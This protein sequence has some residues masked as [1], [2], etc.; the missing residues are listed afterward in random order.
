MCTK[1]TDIILAQLPEILFVLREFQESQEEVFA[2]I[3]DACDTIKY[4]IG[5]VLLLS[6]LCGI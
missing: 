4:V 5:K 6:R 3:N 1:K 2:V